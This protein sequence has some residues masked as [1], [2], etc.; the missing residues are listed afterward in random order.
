MDHL[1]HTPSRE[2]SVAFCAFNPHI[3]R[4]DRV[5][6]SP[7]SLEPDGWLKGQV[8]LKGKG[9]VGAQ[10]NEFSMGRLGLGKQG[11]KLPLQAA[12]E[13]AAGEGVA[14]DVYDLFAA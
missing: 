11:R 1:E 6:L 4:R 2:Y 8:L 3:Q 5:G 12:V 9:K 10:K 7:T 14:D 13:G